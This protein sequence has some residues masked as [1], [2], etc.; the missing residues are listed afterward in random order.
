M[1]EDASPP[2]SELLGL[3]PGSQLCIVGAGGK[4][5]LLYHLGRDVRAAGLQ[6]ITTSTTHMAVGPVPEEFSLILEGKNENRVGKS[7]MALE[8]GAIPLALAGQE[9][10]K[11][12][13]VEP[14]DIQAL[15]QECDVLLVE[16]DGARGRSFKIPRSHEPEIPPGTTHIAILIG[17]D[18][19]DRPVSEETC[20]HPEM[21]P[22]PAAPGGILTPHLARVLLFAA[23][24][25]LRFGGEEI[26]LSIIINKADGPGNMGAAI[27][28]ARWFYYP[29][30]SEVL[31]TSLVEKPSFT[32]AGNGDGA[33]W[34]VMLAAGEGARS[35]G[36]KL[37]WDDDCGVPLIRR[38]LRN[39][40]EGG[41]DGVVLVLGHRSEELR[42]AI[43]TDDI[44]EAIEADEP[45]L[46]V[47]V[48]PEY[49]SGMSSSLR[50]GLK[51]LPDDV[52]GTAILLADQPMVGPELIDSVLVSFRGS[53]CGICRPV[54][55][56]GKGHPVIF[57]EDMF[58]Q[59]HGLTGD[60]GGR[61]VVEEN[62]DRTFE[63]PW[64]R[65]EDFA[66]IDTDEDYRR[67]RR[68]C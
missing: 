8:L 27:R 12:L 4:T 59:L 34:G 36:A 45:R 67:F 28:A 13:G 22:P 11:Y 44:P 23:G 38:S 6:V 25:Y 29:L 61:R 43:D 40:L 32:R 55:G 65:L 18:A 7:R 26:R 3:S 35:G 21:F 60:E 64:D 53:L 56:K 17:W 54:S 46:K 37:L 63:V 57:R 58:D 31:V 49:A 30:V 41:L 15:R 39:A 10:E 48:N 51:A 47:V 5:S 24:G 66:D 62:P 42:A 19:I 33:V 9:G 50:A 20:F 14:G 16:A 52:L 1:G 2:V 68:S